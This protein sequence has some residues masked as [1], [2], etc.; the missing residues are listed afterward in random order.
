MQADK[1][2]DIDIFIETEDKE[3]KDRKINLLNCIQPIK[4]VVIGQYI[5]SSKGP[6]YTEEQGVDKNSITETF[7]AL[8]IHIK[9]NRWD[10]PFYLRTGKGLKRKL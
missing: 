6:S 3:I 9:N 7:A 4:D 10:T 1:S 8:K 2:S 5:K